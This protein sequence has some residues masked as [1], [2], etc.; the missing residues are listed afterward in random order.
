MDNE[1]SDPTGRTAD[2]LRSKKNTAHYY[3]EDSIV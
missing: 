1:T 3:G 2:R